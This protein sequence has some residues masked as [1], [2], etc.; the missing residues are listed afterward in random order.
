[1]LLRRDPVLQRVRHRQI[2]QYLSEERRA[3]GRA[4]LC[5]SGARRKARFCGLCQG[6]RRAQ[7]PVDNF[8]DKHCEDELSPRQALSSIGHIASLRSII[9][10]YFKDLNRK[11]KLRKP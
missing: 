5:I 11:I 2:E 7:A 8:V 4:G 3:S 10:F 9:I 1:L 6:L